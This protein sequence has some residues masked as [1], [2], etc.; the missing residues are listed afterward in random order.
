MNLLSPTNLARFCDRRECESYWQLK[1]GEDHQW[2][3]LIPYPRWRGYG[4]LQRCRSGR[5]CGAGAPGRFRALCPSRSLPPSRRGSVRRTCCI[6]RR[7]MYRPPIPANS[8]PC[9][10]HAHLH[11]AV[12]DLPGDSYDPPF[13]D[14]TYG[15]IQQCGQELLSAVRVTVNWHLVWDAHLKLDPLVGSPREEAS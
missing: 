4:S 5:R 12:E 15:I 3:G 1:S 6:A 13:R 8:W 2:T 14:V 9:V 11:P 7:D 10:L